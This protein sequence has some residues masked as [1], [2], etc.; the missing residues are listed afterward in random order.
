VLCCVDLYHA[1]LVQSICGGMLC[2][3]D[4][5][6]AV[7]TYPILS[8]ACTIRSLEV[9]VP[10]VCP[11]PLWASNQYICCALLSCADICSAVLCC[12]LYLQTHSGGVHPFGNSTLIAGYKSIHMLCI[13]VLR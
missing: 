5:C 3:A 11:P 7:L 10:L 9:C 1:A 8:C 6:L 13:A 12:P 4:L 2:C